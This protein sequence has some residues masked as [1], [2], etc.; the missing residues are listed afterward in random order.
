MA[1]GRPL[2]SAAQPCSQRSSS[3]SSSSSAVAVACGREQGVL[4]GLGQLRLVF[5]VLIEACECMLKD[6]VP[7]A[8]AA[9][10]A[11]SRAT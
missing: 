3:S 11:P 9:A 1:S 6:F 10:S 4:S 5:D 2:A 7:S 8:S